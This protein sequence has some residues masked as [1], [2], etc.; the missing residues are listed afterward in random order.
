MPHPRRAKIV[1]TL[2]PSTSDAPSLKRLIGAGADVLRINLAH[3][4]PPEHARI[5]HLAREVA[6]EAGRTVAFLAD[7][8]GPKMRT[9]PIAG[10]E[11]YLRAGEPFVLAAGEHYGDDR[12]VGTSVHGLASLVTPGDEIFLSDGAIVLE[13]DRTDGGDV[14]T[15]V[16]RGGALRSR[17]GM[18]VPGAE[19]RLEAVTEGDLTAVMGAAALGAELLGLSFVRTANDLERLRASLP[20]GYRPFV[21]SK[22]ETRGA[23]DNLDEIIEVSD[24]VMIARGD[25]GIQTPLASVPEL[26]RRIIR[27]CNRAATPVITATQLLESMTR[28]PLPTRAEVSDVTTAVREG[29]DALMLSEETAIGD[30]PGLVLETMDQVIRAAESTPNDH[31]DPVGDRSD[32][33]VSWGVAHAATVA[34]ADVGAR[35]IL[36]PT[37]TGSTPRRVAAFRPRAEVIGFASGG[38]GLGALC[39]TWGVI[40]VPMDLPDDETIATEAL[41][42]ALDRGIV[43][44]GDRIVIVAGSR[45]GSTDTMQVAT[46]TNGASTHT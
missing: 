34:A 24:G 15:R 38:A 4:D 1:A 46:V 35:A 10:G 27:A 31:S 36:C 6:K 23:I 12:R 41:A 39:L 13:V 19:G 11:V 30:D 40:P 44:P 3:G 43:V 29:T 37:R 17:K 5:V 45:P 18:H 2:G 8:P 21:I 16:L 25:L 33:L 22:I 14:L 26:Q 20:D 28:A 32:D 7:L 9:G 42:R